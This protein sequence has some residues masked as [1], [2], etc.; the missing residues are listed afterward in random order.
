MGS[1]KSFLTQKLIL[2]LILGLMLPQISV[3]ATREELQEQERQAELRVKL[4][5]D[6]VSEDRNSLG[7]VTG[8]VTNLRS[9]IKTMERQLRDN[10]QR[11]TEINKTLDEK[12]A[13]LATIKDGLA[14]TI[15][16]LEASERTS[17]LALFFR[18]DDFSEAIAEI[19]NAQALTEQVTSQYQEIVENTKALSA[20][21]DE[22][23]IAKL[24]LASSRVSLDLQYQALRA[25]EEQQRALLSSSQQLLKAAEQERAEIRKQLFANAYDNTGRSITLDEAIGFAKLASQRI[26]AATGQRMSVPVLL[27][28][29]RH[30][31]NFGNYLGKG[32]YRTSMCN[33]AQK[34]AFVKIT[35]SLGLDPETTP[36][37]K[38]AKNQSCGGAMGYGQ[39]LPL[40]WLGY[41]EKVAQ[42]TGHNPPSPWSPEDAFTATALKLIS[43]GAGK[44]STAA[45]QRRYQWEALM[46]YFSGSRWKNPAI[47]KNIRWY[48]DNILQTADSYVSIIDG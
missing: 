27:A 4:L 37:S 46:T 20:A 2:V 10:E 6:K 34:N 39:F 28:L 40:T 45:E 47:L 44:G 31:S 11:I 32:N 35:E 18:Y 12:E 41:A 7:A 17:M 22:L 15:G 42:I 1:I 16:E 48:A 43:N 24:E 29:V 21:R 19:D 26:E 30:E 9:E 23:E 8:R 3:A 25:E 33:D 14:L 36:V 38:P 5:L 13:A